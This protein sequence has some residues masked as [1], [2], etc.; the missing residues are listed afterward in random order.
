M[1]A[2]ANAGPLI[3]L[4][5]IDHLD[6]LPALFDEVFVPL[7]VRGEVLR[8]S[9]DV[10]GVPALQAAFASGWLTIQEVADRAAV[11]HLTADIDLGEAEAI[12]LTREVAADILLMDEHRGRGLAEREGVPIV[13][14]IGILRAARDRGLIPSATPLLEELQRRQFRVSARLVEQIRREEAGR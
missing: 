7:A 4:S 10:P 13:G 2:V 8:A 5:W 12:A 3:H 6:L 11:A 1:R 9:P 14:T